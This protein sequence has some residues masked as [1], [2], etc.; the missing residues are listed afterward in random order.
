LQRD[1]RDEDV[2]EKRTGAEFK[3]LSSSLHNQARA[4]MGQTSRIVTIVNGVEVIE[5]TTHNP[6]GEP[7]ETNYQV[8]GEKYQTLT[9]A[10]R[11]AQEISESR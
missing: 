1:S 10:R 2:I 9:E 5:V 8:G 7:I 11:V 3:P 4:T 6:E